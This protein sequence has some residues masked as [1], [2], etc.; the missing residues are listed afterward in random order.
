MVTYDITN[1]E[2]KVSVKA[3]PAG[4]Y[5]AVFKGDGVSETVQFVKW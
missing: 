3:L 2:M 4:Q 5:R 1:P